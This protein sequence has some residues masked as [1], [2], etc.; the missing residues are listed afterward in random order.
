MKR[1]ELLGK[2]SQVVGVS[3]AEAIVADAE[4][5][6]GFED[7]ASFSELE[8]RDLCEEIAASYDGYIA[9]IANEVRIHTQAQQRFETLLENVPDP[10]V[11][12]SFPDSVP[13]VKTVNKEFESVFGYDGATTRGLPLA[14]LIVPAGTPYGMDVWLRDDTE[15][16][17]EVIRTT[18]TGE[19]RTFL[20]R[21]A[22]ETTIGGEVEGYGIYTDI[23][24]RI[25]RERN[26][27]TLKQ[28]FS[29]VFRHN[30]RN[31]LTVIKGHIAQIASST[32]DTTIRS[33][34]EILDGATDR[35]LSHTEKTR[36]IEK[37]VDADP[38]RYDVSLRELL[39]TAIPRG[40]ERPETVTI[41]TTVPELS[42]RVVTGFETALENAIENATEHAPGPVTVEI[43]ATADAETVTLRI[44]DDGPGIA[45]NETEMLTSGEE[46]P[47]NHGSG[48]GLW[49][50]SLYVEKSGGE[51]TV[52][53]T[54]AGTT[55]TMALERA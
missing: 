23:T 29:R 50:M 46:T 22:M 15:T 14:D 30:I 41:R 33:S 6:L 7:R 55:V 32:D 12:V 44:V 38:D 24:D 20:R 1:A 10:A 9:E 37:L 43:T 26:L 48:V 54:D 16:D 31:E 49:L 36:D 18:A 13:T 11:I 39:R 45:A 8:I 40:D 28:L 5:T 3:K 25:E 19:E 35:L 51:L 2:F 53:G 27:H 47:L 21:T 34:T 52:S 17:D 42:V 4:L